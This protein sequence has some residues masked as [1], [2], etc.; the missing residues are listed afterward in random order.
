MLRLG[1]SEPLHKGCNWDRQ[2]EETRPL[3]SN[4][5][6]SIVLVAHNAEAKLTDDVTRLLEIS[7]DIS[8]FFDLLI[9][10]DGSTDETITIAGDL[11]RQYPQVNAYHNAMRYGHAAA[12][13]TGIRETRGEYVFFC[14]PR[15]SA[16]QMRKLWR[17]RT[18]PQFVMAQPSTASGA[19]EADSPQNTA[20]L[21][22]RLIH[23][24]ALLSRQRRYDAAG[25]RIFRSIVTR[26]AIGLSEPQYL[27]RTV[28]DGLT[29]DGPTAAGIRNIAGMRRQSASSEGTAKNLTLS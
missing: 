4:N 11:A 27:V 12:L 7:S 24:Q 23:R 16:S 29:Q 2:N 10:D 17:I 21:G 14:T 15:P 25:K 6:L 13:Q 20:G 26:D 18:S 22:I 5:V 19:A 8:P 28:S 9:I 3:V 1:T